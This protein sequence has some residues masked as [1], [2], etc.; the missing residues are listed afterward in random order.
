MPTGMC[1]QHH[2]VFEF[3]K[4]YNAQL[5]Q[6]FEA[7][8]DHGLAP[9]VAPSLKGVYA[10]YLSGALV[11]PGKALDTT[12]RRR[13][14]EPFRKI[15]GRQNISNADMSCRFL[16][17]EGDW[18]VRAAEDALIQYYTP[19]WNNSGFGSHLPGIG[20]PGV[21]VSK[22]DTQYPPKTPS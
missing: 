7:S 8:P 21:R 17:I 9:E 14:N 10:L 2:F 11:Y 3:D 6:K 15:E 13:L 20:R 18:F 16:T 5:I 1:D 4:A 22:W 19:I 12:L